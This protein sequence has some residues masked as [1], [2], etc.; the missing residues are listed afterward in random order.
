MLHSVIGLEYANGYAYSIRAFQNFEDWK[1]FDTKWNPGN[2]IS[3][4]FGLLFGIDMDQ[5]FEI[6]I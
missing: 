1:L 6:G 4:R 2:T 5:L 3:N